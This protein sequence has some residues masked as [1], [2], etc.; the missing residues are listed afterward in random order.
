MHQQHFAF[1]LSSGVVTSIMN[2]FTVAVKA[3]PAALINER[4]EGV[5]QAF[6]AVAVQDELS[7][8]PFFQRDGAFPQ[9]SAIRLSRYKAGRRC[10]IEYD[11]LVKHPSRA[12][13]LLTLMA[14]M[15]IKSH[16]HSTWAVVNGLWESGMNDQADDGIALP[17]PVGEIPHWHVWL[18]PKVPGVALAPLF[19]GPQG[20]S[21]AERV[22]EAAHKIHHSSVPTQRHHSMADELA[23][24]SERLGRTAS[25]YPQWS[26]RIECVINDCKDLGNSLPLTSLCGIHRDF[27]ADQI[28]A[29]DKML[30]LLDFDLYCMGDPA[31]DIGNF[32]AH[33]TEYSLRILGDATALVHV[34]QALAAKFLQLNPHIDA[35]TINAYATLT[36]AR[37]IHISTLFAERR[38]YTQALLELVEQR[39]DRHLTCHKHSKYFREL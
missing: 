38:A 26:D 39:L 21:L 2:T 31:L 24:L 30:Y 3:P 17:R 12:P 32:I 4:F 11:L 35:Q 1:T 29:D 34:E 23:I 8:L 28:I 22:A 14:K 18:Q 36:L 5:H 6:D 13:Q 16:D 19:A 25:A 7:R 20:E 10:L 37:H 27:Y 33:I 9:L 15:R